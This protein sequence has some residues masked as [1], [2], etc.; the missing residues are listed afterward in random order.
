MKQ[1]SFILV[2]ALALTLTACAIT[3]ADQLSKEDAIAIALQT[4]GLDRNAIRDL[5]AEKERELGVTVWEVDFVSG[6]QE[7]SFVLDAQSGQ[8]L[9][10]KT[11]RD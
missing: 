9:R 6:T 10:Q 8:V 3:P 1:V 2:L 7:Y 4:A 5:E 11:E